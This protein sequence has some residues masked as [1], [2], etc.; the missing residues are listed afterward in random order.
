MRKRVVPAFQGRG[1][2]C[3]RPL[4][5]RRRLFRGGAERVAVEIEPE[6]PR[7]EDPIRNPLLLQKERFVGGVGDHRIGLAVDQIQWVAVMLTRGSEA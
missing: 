6:R 1:S 5:M 4:R 7:R 3:P 2:K